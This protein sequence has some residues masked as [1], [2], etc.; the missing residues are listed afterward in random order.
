M[1]F[2]VSSRERVDSV[3]VLLNAND[4]SEIS[5]VN[6]FDAV[7][8]V[9]APKKLEGEHNLFV[10]SRKTAELSMLLLESLD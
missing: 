5:F 10:K 6:R 1:S 9:F 8:E 7:V 3:S 4:L 2:E